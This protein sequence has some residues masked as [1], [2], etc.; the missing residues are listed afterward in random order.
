VEKRID[1][2]AGPNDAQAMAVSMEGG[3]VYVGGYMMD[4]KQY[5]P[6]YWKDGKRIELTGTSADSSVQAVFVQQ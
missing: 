2:P 6:C 3:V 5:I 1:L 4:K